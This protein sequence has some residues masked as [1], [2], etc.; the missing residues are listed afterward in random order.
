[1]TC[2]GLAG[3]VMF[4]LYAA[5][6]ALLGQWFALTDK[7]SILASVMTVVAVVGL[8][9]AGMF[10]MMSVLYRIDPMGALLRGPWFILSYWFGFGALV[11]VFWMRYAWRQLHQH[12]R[13][14]ASRVP[15]RNR[16]WELLKRRL[17]MAAP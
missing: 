4:T 3:L 13:E 1:V 2:I 10:A 5:A 8:H 17:G 9:W 7:H 16:F 12:F 11:C 14:A 6:I 15:L